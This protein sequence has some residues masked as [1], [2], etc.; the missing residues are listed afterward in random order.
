MSIRKFEKDDLEKVIDLSEMSFGKSFDTRLYLAISESW[1]EA[2]TVYEEEGIVRGFLAGSMPYPTEGRILMLAVHP[3]FRGRGIGSA[4]LENFIGLCNRE[5]M[6]RI[7]LEVRMSNKTAI[8]FYT[9][10]GFSR[11]SISPGYY[12]NGEDALIMWK[13]L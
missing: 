8:S 13:S 2:F 5:G 3:D 1:P 9:K 10:H 4:L 12:E 6:R 7:Y 11:G